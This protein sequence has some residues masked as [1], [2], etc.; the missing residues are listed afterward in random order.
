MELVEAHAFRRGKKW[1]KNNAFRRCGCAVTAAKAGFLCR[2]IPTAEAVGFHDNM[3][4]K[5]FMKQAVAAGWKIRAS[6]KLR[7]GFSIL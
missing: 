1:S 2:L 4:S 5:A 7:T 3:P 6:R